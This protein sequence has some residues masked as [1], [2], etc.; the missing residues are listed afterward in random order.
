MGDTKHRFYYIILIYRPRLVIGRHLNDF[1][2]LLRQHYTTN[3][4]TTLKVIAHDA[5]EKRK[6]EEG[7]K[8]ANIKNTWTIKR[9]TKIAWH[10]I[11]SAQCFVQERAW[12][13][14]ACIHWSAHKKWN[15]NDN[16]TTKKAK[17]NEEN[18]FMRWL[19][20][21]SK[22]KMLC[23][24]TTTMTTTAAAA[25]IFRLFSVYTLLLLY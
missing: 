19:P 10:A 6:K 25:H 15:D 17:R 24:A 21:S 14:Y 23:R 22:W 7:A 5:S 8:N 18:W 20:S 2:L 9:V 11:A 12:S 16:I 3:D 13:I 4:A 1:S